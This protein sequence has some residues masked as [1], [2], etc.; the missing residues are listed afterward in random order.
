MR[1]TFVAS[2]GLISAVP[3]A[4][5]ALE[6][7]WPDCPYPID[8]AYN[9]VA[10]EVEGLR[11]TRLIKRPKP[12]HDWIGNMIYYIRNY[13]MVDPFLLLL[14]DYLVCHLVE[15]RIALT[16][17]TIA[18]PEVGMVRI[19]PTP[20]PS[21]P[22]DGL[23][24]Q[25]DMTAPYITSLQAA[26]WKPATMLKICE[27]LIAR[28][29]HTAWNFELEGSRIASTLDLPL[30]L[31]LLRDFGGMSYQNLYVRGKRFA[32]AEEWIRNNLS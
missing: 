10:P 30:F 15:D 5:K 24:G 9:A 13:N 29:R 11:Y 32:P 25:F 12:N 8:V 19:V 26:W 16:A 31:G 23:I 1:I 2:D 27:A 17:D 4:L 22:Y 18:K 20:G 7:A 3:Y 14:E 28:G 21:L 6:K